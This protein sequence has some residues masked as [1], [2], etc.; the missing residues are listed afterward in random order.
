[1]AT[2][3]QN[4]APDSDA[5]AQN[6]VSMSA[7]AKDS[8]IYADQ[9]SSV[10]EVY[11]QILLRI[12][13]GELPSGSVLTSTRL[14]TQLNVSR[15]PIVAA[16]DRLVAEGILQKEKNR[17]AIVRNGAEH[18]L[19]QIHQ[20]RIIVEPPAAALAAAR[21]T[22]EAISELDRLRRAAEPNRSEQWMKAARKFD[23]ALH[24][25]IADH[26]GN[27]PLRKTIYKSWTYKKL[28]FDAGY[29]LA[30]PAES[31]YR[32]HVAIL[33]ALSRHDAETASAAMLFHL[34]SAS[35]I[36]NE[37]GIS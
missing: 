37:L 32:E 18:W 28:V 29:N 35:H 1:M 31:G 19:A 13:K 30:N 36:R 25:A 2:I 34:R 12:V 26:C 11:S 5:L 10:D 24:L 20:L 33:E 21:I 14:A 17:R 8:A 16:L 9:T 4:L 23:H 22:P 6:D 3:V 27:L 15:T 7:T